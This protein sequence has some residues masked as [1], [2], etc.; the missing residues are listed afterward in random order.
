MVIL[1]NIKKFTDK[2]SYL[3]NSKRCR[4][5][6]CNL[7][8][9]RRRKIVF[10]NWDALSKNQQNKSIVKPI[11]S[12]A[13]E[14]C[15]LIHWKN[16]PDD[17]RTGPWSTVKSHYFYDQPRSRLIESSRAFIH[18]SLIWYKL[19]KRPW[20]TH[21]FFSDALKCIIYLCP[22]NSGMKS[23]SVTL[24]LQ[25]GIPDT[26]RYQWTLYGSEQHY[27]SAG[28]SLQTFFNFSK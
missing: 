2:Y 28:H 10:D 17:L 12:I 18:F 7:Q 13:I 22:I 9:L 24:S 25:S 26:L 15:L 4:T 23:L 21:F 1:D 27:S 6:R 20:E 5:L 11:Y 16:F 8:Y 14:C 3:L 19:V